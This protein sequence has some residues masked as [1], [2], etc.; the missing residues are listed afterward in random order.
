M[1]NVVT[2]REGALSC[3]LCRHGTAHR[4]QKGIDRVTSKWME[5]VMGTEW[6]IGISLPQRVLIFF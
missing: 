1:E 6:K 4:Y 3:G 5:R 2:G